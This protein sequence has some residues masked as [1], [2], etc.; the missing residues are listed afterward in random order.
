MARKADPTKKIITA[1]KDE[2][3]ITAE[4]VKGILSST[5]SEDVKE[6][7]EAY[8]NKDFKSIKQLMG[9]DASSLIALLRTLC[10]AL[11]KLH[12]LKCYL[13]EGMSF[14]AACKALR[15]PPFFKEKDLLKNQISLWHSDD[16][17]AAIEK[18]K[19]LEI[20]IKKNAPGSLE[21]VA[22]QLSAILNQEAFSTIRL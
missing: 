9:T 7:V 21:K 13:D 1:T 19:T 8:L 15:P 5:K 11:L 20:D 10:G 14:E 6:F 12:S 4:A 22:V 18:T 17:G 3:E 2:G 16:L